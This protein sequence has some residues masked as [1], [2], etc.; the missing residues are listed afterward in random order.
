M[1]NISKKKKSA[2]D[3]KV[4]I[5]KQDLKSFLSDSLSID[6]FWYDL[7]GIQPDKKS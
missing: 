4:K 3:F 1:N 5:P 2:K 7:Y 6:P